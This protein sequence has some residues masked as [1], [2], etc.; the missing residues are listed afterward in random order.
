MF[1]KVTDPSMLEESFK[2]RKTV[3][4]EEQGVP[5][6]N[7]LDEY[8]QISTH[9]IGYENK[10]AIAAGRIRPLKENIGKIERIAIL[11][12][13]RGQGYGKK[14]ML[15]IEEIAY[16]NGYKEL[17]LNA[18]THA[19]VFYELLGFEA[20]GEIFSEENIEHIKMKK[21]L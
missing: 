8:E 1:K 4:V 12:P 18:Q 15:A 10:E 19:Q 13:Y 16:E 17:V 9:V 20:Y 21:E 11:K 6:E 3:F 7:E 5:D 14:L 2:I